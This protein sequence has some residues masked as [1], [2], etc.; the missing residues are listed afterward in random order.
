MA[1]IKCPDCGQDIS[2]KATQCIHCGC[3]ISPKTNI[4]KIS[5]PYPE[6]KKSYNNVD[7]DSSKFRPI[8]G[9][10]YIGG[11]EQKSP[12]TMKAYSCPT[13]GKK[14]AANATFCPN[15]GRRDP[16]IARTLKI[17]LPIL[18]LMILLIILTS[19]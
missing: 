8:N 15:C 16:H 10:G 2:D 4:D 12:F 6:P 11:N 19:R 3:P 9:A 5:F 1:L 13:C 18:G 17:V 7:I 14:L